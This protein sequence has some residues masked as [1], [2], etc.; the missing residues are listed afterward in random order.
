[1]ANFTIKPAQV[2]AAINAQAEKPDC[3]RPIETKNVVP[4]IDKNVDFAT[5]QLEWTASRREIR[6]T[7]SGRLFVGPDRCRFSITVSSRKES[8]QDVKNSVSRRKDYVLQ[9][10]RNNQVRDSDF[11]VNQSLQRINNQYQLDDE[12][13]V[14][15]HDFDKFE[16]IGNLL[17]EKLDDHVK[18]SQPEFDHSPNNIEGLRKQAA[19]LALQNGKQKAIDLAQVVNARIGRV[20]SI[21]E[22]SVSEWEGLTGDA[23]SDA[24]RPLSVDQLVKL[25]TVHVE[26]RVTVAFELV[27]KHKSKE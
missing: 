18:I 27:P 22:E 5:P 23:A 19:V 17:V 13:I 1:M 3:F 24:S 2:F 15:L 4:K 26:A 21:R 11:K 14:N 8:I 16:S 25:A 10:L 12:V 9:T 6:V 7:A 20:L